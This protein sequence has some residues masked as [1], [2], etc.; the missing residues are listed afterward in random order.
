MDRSTCSRPTSRWSCGGT[1]GTSPR[2]QAAHLVAARVLA[3]E[4]LRSGLWWRVAH[5]ARLRHQRQL[6]S[7]AAQLEEPPHREIREFDITPG[8]IVL[9]EPIVSEQDS[10]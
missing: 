7:G 9:G 6:R 3:G 8:G 10:R 1:G 4:A 2:A 5:G